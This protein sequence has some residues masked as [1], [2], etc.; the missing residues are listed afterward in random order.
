MILLEKVSTYT[1]IY[2]ITPLQVNDLCNCYEKYDTVRN[3][4]SLRQ[5]CIQNPVKQLR[6]NVLQK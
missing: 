1:A 4:N 2:Q 3:L 5:R 6:R